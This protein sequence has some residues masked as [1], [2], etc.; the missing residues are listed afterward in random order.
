MR[1]VVEQAAKLNTIHSTLRRCAVCARYK[2]AARQSKHTLYYICTYTEQTLDS[3]LDSAGWALM[4][5]LLCYLMVIGEARPRAIG[6]QR[7]LRWS[8]ST[9][10]PDVVDVV[11]IRLSAL[12]WLFDVRQCVHIIKSKLHKRSVYWTS[13]ARVRLQICIA[14]IRLQ[15]DAPCARV[16]AYINIMDDGA[17]CTLIHVVN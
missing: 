1:C 16:C 6:H 14:F 9:S 12:C 11:V 3:R 8:S 4:F 10:T 13:Y 2:N 5:S 15:T 17:V 7:R